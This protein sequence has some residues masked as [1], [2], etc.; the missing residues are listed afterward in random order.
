MK[1]VLKSFVP[2]L[3]SASLVAAQEVREA[4]PVLLNDI[5]PDMEAVQERRRERERSEDMAILSQILYEDLLQLYLHDPHATG[6]DA[7]AGRD[8][9]ITYEALARKWFLRA[10]AP[11]EEV[12]GPLAEYLPGYGMVIQVQTPPPQSHAAE[13]SAQGDAERLSRWEITRRRMR[14]EAAYEGA[15]CT[16]CHGADAPAAV[17]QLWSSLFSGGRDPH[18]GL[19]IAG[20]ARRP[21]RDQLIAALADVL[22]EAGGRLRHVQPDERITLSAQYVPDSRPPGDEAFLRRVYLDLIG[23]LPAREEVE[24]FLA[25]RSPEKRNRVVQ[26]LSRRAGSSNVKENAKAPRSQEQLDRSA[27]PS[28]SEPPAASDASGVRSAIDDLILRRLQREESIA[29]PETPLRGRISVTATRR[30]IDAL[31]AGAMDRAE[32]S[33]QIVVRIFDPTGSSKGQLVPAA[34]GPE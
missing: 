33:K 14:G 10:A 5:S 28:A 31:A 8:P 11:S 1:T 13:A 21:T 32:F 6:A 12:R 25:D 4:E 3:I 18:Q 22:T 20:A 26:E 27:S 34:A 17:D 16:A 23:E 9:N 15:A 30:Q 7:R 24:S 2:F 19:S 29:G